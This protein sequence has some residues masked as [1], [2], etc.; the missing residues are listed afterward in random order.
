MR[1][2][3]FTLVE[4]LVA[5]SLTAVAA[6]LVA[7]SF[8]QGIRAVKHVRSAV[9]ERRFARSL[10]SRL[11]KDLLNAVSFSTAS[12]RGG[13]GRLTFASLDGTPKSV[14]YDLFHGSVF[15]TE[16]SV[17]G[18]LLER[19][20]LVRGVRSWTVGYAYRE[21]DGRVDFRPVWGKEQSGI[22]RTVRMRVAFESVKD[23]RESLWNLPQGRLGV[24]EGK[25]A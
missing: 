10:E 5:L 8:R 4:L 9:D 6:P 13:D 1:A 19:R 16:R 25:A 11:E 23:E 20:E 24:I 3:G 18:G 17:S 7:N 22:P 12:F 15:R 21:A 14:S 2:H